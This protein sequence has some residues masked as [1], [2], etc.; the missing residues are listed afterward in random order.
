MLKM[1][2][3]GAATGSWLVPVL[4]M[5]RGGYCRENVGG[6]DAGG[7]DAAGG[8]LVGC[9]QNAAYLPVPLLRKSRMSCWDCGKRFPKYI[10]VCVT[11][12]REAAEAELPST[13]RSPLGASP[14]WPAVGRLQCCRE[15]GD[16]S[17]APHKSSNEL[18]C[19]TD[20]KD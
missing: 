11:A 10:V 19:Q 5:L 17:A 2:G 13:S 6:K 4:R 12:G 7:K 1:Q 8:M 9:R 20:Q 16:V 18:I 3:L 14:R 15:P